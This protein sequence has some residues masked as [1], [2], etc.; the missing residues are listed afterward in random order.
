MDPSQKDLNSTFG[1]QTYNGSEQQE[2]EDEDE[3][4]FGGAEGSQQQI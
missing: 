4:R 2:D 3:P 1:K